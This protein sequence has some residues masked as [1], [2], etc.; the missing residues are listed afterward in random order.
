[1][2]GHL[3]SAFSGILAQ[4]Q[5]INKKSRVTTG[6]AL[7]FK[8]LF[9]HIALIV[10]GGHTM[11]V[12]MENF[13]NYNVIGQTVDDAAG[14]A[15]DKVAKLLGLPYPGGPVVSKLAEKGKLQFPSPGL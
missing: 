1:M 9:P 12:L 11:L 10:S 15:F 3:Y 8:N 4:S 2:T 5:K 6:N 13:I 7:S 14:E